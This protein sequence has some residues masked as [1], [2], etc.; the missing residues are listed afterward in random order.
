MGGITDHVHG[1]SKI[2]VVVA[3]LAASSGCA[4]IVNDPMVP[5]EFI[6]QG[7]ERLQCTAR[8]K[9][10]QWQVEAPGTAMIRRSDD[11]LHV[12]CTD[13]AGEQFRAQVESEIEVEKLAGSVVF[14]DLGIT[15]SITD[16]HRDYPRQVLVACMR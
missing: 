11:T 8:N 3:A 4:T 5:V 6:P 15:D 7:C 2:M 1:S 16:K 13:A 12:E 10:G 9:R 14:F